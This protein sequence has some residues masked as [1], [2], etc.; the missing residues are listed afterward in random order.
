MANSLNPYGILPI[1]RAI[2]G[3]SRVLMAHWRAPLLTIQWNSFRHSLYGSL[4]ALFSGPHAPRQFLGGKYFRDCWIDRGIPKRAVAAAG[5]IHVIFFLLPYPEMPA[6]RRFV[7]AK[8]EVQLTWSKP[9]EDLPPVNLNSEAPK[10]KASAAPVSE[11]E[12]QPASAGTDAYHPRQTI[13]TD[14][15][16][17]THPRQTVINPAAPPEPPKILP[18]LP[19]IVQVAQAA[20]PARPRLVIKREDLAKLV[21]RPRTMRAP[22]DV[23]LPQIPNAEKQIADL[24]LAKYSPAI[25]KP[26]MPLNASAAPRT[27]PRVAAGGSGPTPDLQSAVPNGA[28]SQ[29]FIALSAIPAPPQPQLP[30]VNGNLSARIAISPQ[31]AKDGAPIGAASS[32][33][34][35]GREASFGSPDSLGGGRGT[36]TQGNA[37]TTVIVSGGKPSSSLSISG[38]GDGTRLDIAGPA[39]HAAAR[40]LPDKPGPSAAAS[41]TARRTRAPNFGQL[42]PGA[43]PENILGAKRIYTLNVNMPNL[44]SAMGSWVLSFAELRDDATEPGSLSESKPGLPSDLIGPVPL[45]KVDPKYPPALIQEKVEGEVVLYAVIRRDGSVDSIQLVRGIDDQLDTN[46]MQALSRW[47]FRPGERAGAPVELEAIVHI[48]FR[49][50]RSRF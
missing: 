22:E 24:N 30:L 45:R 44:S 28:A 15:F 42:P 18:P 40:N 41:D 7:L 27:V 25:G 2:T 35:G 29:T 21:P 12:K 6:P 50:V 20:L 32:A 37:S 48:P 43:K 13:F 8:P 5:A 26:A 38:L 46:A 34:S 17:P 49:F 14:A 47:K 4:H 3:K 10:P 23:S 36:S 19:N 11:R 39:V 33:T 9:A 31:G 16:H 1:P